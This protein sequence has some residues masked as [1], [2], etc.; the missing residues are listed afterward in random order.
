VFDVDKPLLSP[1]LASSLGHTASDYVPSY[2][3]WDSCGLTV[4]LSRKIYLV[5]STQHPLFSRLALSSSFRV[6]PG[7]CTYESLSSFR[8][9]FS[10]SC[11]ASYISTIISML[12][13]RSP[14]ILLSFPWLSLSIPQ[15]SVLSPLFRASTLGGIFRLLCATKAALGLFGWNHLAWRGSNLKTPGAVLRNTEVTDAGNPAIDGKLLR[16]VNGR[17]VPHILC[18]H[19]CFLWS[20]SHA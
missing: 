9:L 1:S 20:D 11:T 14:P 10:Q 6:K 7:L 4:R 16:H 2:S 19:S 12:L 17:L 15:P 5:D 18:S 3:T 13:A 8:R